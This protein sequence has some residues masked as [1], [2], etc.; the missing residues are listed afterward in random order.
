VI[1]IY[2]RCERRERSDFLKLLRKR[3]SFDL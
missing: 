2:V 3:T 1:I